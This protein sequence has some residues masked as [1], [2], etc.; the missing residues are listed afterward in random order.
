METINIL[1]NGEPHTQLATQTVQGLLSQL[2]LSNQ[3][4]AIEIN[5]TLVP[6]ST[7]PHHKLQANDHIEIV[8]AIGGG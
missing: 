2:V 1:L 7:Y 5:S 4:Y 3:R 8:Q 6:R